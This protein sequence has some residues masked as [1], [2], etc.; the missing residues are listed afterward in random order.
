MAETAPAA[1]RHPKCTDQ[2]GTQNLTL[3]I[4]RTLTAAG[5]PPRRSHSRHLTTSTGTLQWC[6]RAR[7]P[8]RVASAQAVSTVLLRR[9]HH[10]GISD[11]GIRKLKGLRFIAVAELAAFVAAHDSRRAHH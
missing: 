6:L 9:P 10:D 1:G 7:M 8:G 4:P 3:N 2:A 5:R 11:K